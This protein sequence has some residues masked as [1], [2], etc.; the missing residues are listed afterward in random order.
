MRSFH[1]GT[2]NLAINVSDDT[3]STTASEVGDN[4]DGGQSQHDGVSGASLSGAHLS[5]NKIQ[6]EKDQE[7]GHLRVEGQ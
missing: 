2:D 4:G 6:E 1:G 7:V 5:S 3:V